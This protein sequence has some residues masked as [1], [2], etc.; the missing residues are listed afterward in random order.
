[1]RRL[2]RPHRLSPGSAAVSEIA[3]REPHPCMIRIERRDDDLADV[4]SH[5]RLA[6]AGPHDFQDDVLVHHQAVS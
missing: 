1:M 4:A 6:G 3:D 2:V 5:N